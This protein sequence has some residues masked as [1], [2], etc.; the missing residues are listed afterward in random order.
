VLGA[1]GS[2]AD[3]NPY[4]WPRISGLAFVPDLISLAEYFQGLLDQKR[5]DD[6]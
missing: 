3:K 6:S 4:Q 5:K 2:A 1:F